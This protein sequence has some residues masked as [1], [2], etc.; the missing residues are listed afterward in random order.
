[1]KAGRLEGY[2]EDMDGGK[3]MPK[4]DESL[5][6]CGFYKIESIPQF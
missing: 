6:S 3:R 1:L 5:R 2:G 4:I